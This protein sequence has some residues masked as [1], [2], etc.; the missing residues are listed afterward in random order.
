MFTQDERKYLQRRL[1]SNEQRASALD[2]RFRADKSR[3][4]AGLED[5]R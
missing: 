1:A 4:Q 2:E 5:Y 3:L